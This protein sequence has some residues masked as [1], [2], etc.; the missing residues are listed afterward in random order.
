MIRKE[1]KSFSGRACALFV[2]VS[3][4]AM[5]MMFAAVAPAFA[6]T[7]KKI[8]VTFVRT[9]AF[10]TLPSDVWTTDGDT[11]HSRGSLYGFNSYKVT[12]PGVN[13]VGSSQS[14]VDQNFNNNTNVGNVHYDGNIVFPDGTFEGVTNVRGTFRDYLSKN[15]PG[16]LA[17]N[18]TVSKGM[19]H[20]TGAY[21]G[22]TLVVEGNYVNGTALPATGYLLI[23]NDD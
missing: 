13:L 8:P 14:V 3:A 7:S 1:S 23:P 20:G 16:M 9:G 6:E 15:Y 22:W 5:I 19:Y 4:L 10:S 21:Q 17:P 2:I 11:Y 12:G 18:D